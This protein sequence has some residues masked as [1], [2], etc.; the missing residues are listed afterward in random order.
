MH[1]RASQLTFAAVNARGSCSSAGSVQSLED[2]LLAKFKAMPSITFI[3]EA[4][5]R[6]GACAPQVSSADAV[7]TPF[8]DPCCTVAVAATSGVEA[9]AGGERLVAV[10][11]RSVLGGQGFDPNHWHHQADLESRLPGRC[12]TSP[13]SH[14]VERD[15]LI[16]AGRISSQADEAWNTT[17]GCVVTRQ[18]LRDGFGVK[19]L[20]PKSTRMIRQPIACGRFV[21]AVVSEERNLDSK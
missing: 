7:R 11:G 8:V 9:A 5:G 4:D 19:S 18:Q 17:A 20:I 15:F 21:L 1:E 13:Q 14:L 2:A 3:I 6:V 16:P 12:Q 10:E